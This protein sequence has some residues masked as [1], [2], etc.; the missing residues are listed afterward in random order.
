MLSRTPGAYYTEGLANVHCFSLLFLKK[1]IAKE[2]EWDNIVSR[3]MTDQEWG[4]KDTKSCDP[5]HATSLYLIFHSSPINCEQRSWEPKQDLSF[6]VEFTY[7]AL[8]QIQ[9]G[10][11]ASSHP[12][13]IHKLL[14]LSV[15]QL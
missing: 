7:Q 1:K 13:S 11:L 3:K 10:I 4:C 15:H 5:D 6:K 2:P 8:T 9:I 12:E 14:G